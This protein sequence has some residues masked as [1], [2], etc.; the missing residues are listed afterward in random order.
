MI[1]NIKFNNVLFLRLIYYN[2][3]NVQ[4]MVV[5]MLFPENQHFKDCLGVS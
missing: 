1:K 3:V 5:E 4:H 2:Y